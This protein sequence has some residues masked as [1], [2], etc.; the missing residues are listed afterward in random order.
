MTCMWPVLLRFPPLSAISSDPH[1]CN[2]FDAGLMV[3]R[4]H[5]LD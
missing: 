2:S 5:M 1:L 4:K 3:P